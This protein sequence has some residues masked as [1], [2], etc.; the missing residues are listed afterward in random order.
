MTEQHV[1][2]RKR[3]ILYALLCV[4]EAY[5][6]RLINIQEKYNN[7]VVVTAVPVLPYHVALIHTRGDFHALR[8][9]FFFAAHETTK[10]RCENTLGT[11][12]DPA[13]I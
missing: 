1:V 12:V 3:D 11:T 7:H 5:L 10:R 2:C 9:I 6:H 8:V 4:C 13:P